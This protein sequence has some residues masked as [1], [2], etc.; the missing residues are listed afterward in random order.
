MQVLLFNVQS[1]L[2]MERR[3]ELANAINALGFD[4]ISTETWF[5]TNINSEL[6]LSQFEIYRAERE[7]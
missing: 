4:I 5:Y 7:Y 1:I 2:T 6:H 3:T